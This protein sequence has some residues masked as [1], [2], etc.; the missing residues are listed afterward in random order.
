MAVQYPDE[1]MRS[2]SLFNAV[3]DDLFL[4]DTF[5]TLEWDNLLSLEDLPSVR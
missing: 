4:H 5:A 3:E 2:L 1:R